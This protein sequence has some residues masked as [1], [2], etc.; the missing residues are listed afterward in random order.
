[1]VARPAFDDALP[2]VQSRLAHDSEDVALGWRN[3]GADQKIHAPERVKVS[4]MV[5][6]EKRHV[7]QLAQVSP[8]GRGGDPV[9]IVERLQRRHHVGL[10]ADSA[11][12]TRDGG[13]VAGHAT[14]AEVLETPQL[15]H[16]KI[17][18]F[19]LAG[20][21]E[22]DLDATVSFQ[23]GDGVDGDGFSHVLFSRAAPSSELAS[24][25]L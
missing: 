3:V 2:D 15:R 10:W 7:Q 4:G 14:D 17:D 5:A 11:D 8:P 21:V 18:I 24:V 19:D 12:A 6:D 25:N 9:Q 13:H 22:E 1:M 23:P 20:L 16:L